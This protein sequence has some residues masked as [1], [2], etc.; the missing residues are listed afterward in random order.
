MSSQRNERFCVDANEQFVPLALSHKL[1]PVIALLWANKCGEIDSRLT[2]LTDGYMI[3]RTNKVSVLGAIKYRLNEFIINFHDRCACSCPNAEHLFLQYDIQELEHDFN[4]GCKEEFLSFAEIDK[5]VRRNLAYYQKTISPVFNYNLPREEVLSSFDN[6]R[7]CNADR[8]LGFDFVSEYFEIHTDPVPFFVDPIIQPAIIGQNVCVTHHD[9]LTVDIGNEN[10]AYECFK[11][12]HSHED[13]KEQWVSL[14]FDGGVARFDDKPNLDW[15]PDHSA[16]QRIEQIDYPVVYDCDL[17]DNLSRDFPLESKRGDEPA[18]CGIV[19]KISD[20]WLDLDPVSRVKFESKPSA[21]IKCGI[22]LVE[23][24]NCSKTQFK[25]REGKCFSCVIQPLNA[26][27]KIVVFSNM[28]EKSKL[29][30]VNVTK[31]VSID[32]EVDQTNRFKIY[33]MGLTFSSP[34]CSKVNSE[35]YI[36]SDVINTNESRLNQTG[37]FGFGVSEI[38]DLIRIRERLLDLIIEGYVFV[39]CDSRLEIAVMESMQLPD[40]VI[41]DLQLIDDRFVDQRR[42]LRSYCLEYDIS[43]D[44]LHNS[45]NDSR[46]VYEVFAQILRR[47]PDFAGRFL[48][49]LNFDNEFCCSECEKDAVDEF[50][51]GIDV[52]IF[53]FKFVRRAYCQYLNREKYKE[54]MLWLTE[55][56]RV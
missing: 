53:G 40:F 35:H 51:S 32:F 8:L 41:L 14:T 38:V 54:Y 36:V 55:F 30:G 5:I 49:L 43:D 33:E 3:M 27:P 28:L 10:E 7:V 1:F 29:R 26:V 12:V 21:C 13:L 18:F 46:A 42:S 19:P 6:Y 50:M 37:N 2:P 56:V 48:L 31:L 44:N 23:Q 4:D 45:G 11:R 25:K 22:A 39:A 20:N 16:E 47:I 34:C 15:G 17:A 52:D 9:L 24:V